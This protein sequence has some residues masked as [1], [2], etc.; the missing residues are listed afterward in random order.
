MD[1]SWGGFH[2]LAAMPGFFFM[3]WLRMSSRLSFS[4]SRISSVGLTLRT[5]YCSFSSSS[6]SLEGFLS[7]WKARS[8]NLASFFSVVSVN[9]PSRDEHQEL[10]E[11]LGLTGAC[12]LSPSRSLGW[13]GEWPLARSPS[14]MGP[15]SLLLSSM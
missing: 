6:K 8:S 14:A 13:P 7:S 9:S 11:E 2:H 5:Q 1:F 3:A 12:R 4:S 15:G 10:V